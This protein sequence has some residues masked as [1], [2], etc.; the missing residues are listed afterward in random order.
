MVISSAI[1]SASAASGTTQ[2]SSFGAADSGKLQ[3]SSA[4]ATV[5][6]KPQISTVA[7]TDPPGKPQ[8]LSS[9]AAVDSGKAQTSSTKPQTSPSA[10]N[11]VRLLK[12]IFPV[13]QPIAT[14]DDGHS[15]QVSSRAFPVAGR[16]S[17]STSQEFAV[18]DTRNYCHG[19]PD[20]SQASSSEMGN[21]KPS[22]VTAFN[23]STC[24]TYNQPSSSSSTLLTYKAN[25]CEPAVTA[26]SA[27]ASTSHVRTHC[28]NVHCCF[29]H[30]LMDGWV[31][32]K[33]I[34]T[35]SWL[36]IRLIGLNLS[37]LKLNSVIEDTE[38][39]GFGHR[40]ASVNFFR[41]WQNRCGGQIGH[42]AISQCGLVV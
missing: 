24:L 33:K 34:N 19:R 36:C 20:K 38:S 14:G 30:G 8:P 9:V 35:S 21:F 11:D 37:L 42:R 29:C 10:A 39:V 3:T 6:G 32:A 23:A 18:A 2:T 27:A 22:S 5:S 4:T 13:S 12:P 15:F 28:F 17:Q 25:S 31:V 16:K 26:T 40:V 1:M 7:A 41:V